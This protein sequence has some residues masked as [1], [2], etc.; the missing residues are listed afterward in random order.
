MA[1]KSRHIVVDVS[2]FWLD[3]EKGHLSEMPFLL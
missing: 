3:M 2:A 1:V